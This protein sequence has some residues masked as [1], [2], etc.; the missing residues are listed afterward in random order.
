MQSK[1]FV[2]ARLSFFDVEFNNCLKDLCGG[3]LVDLISTLWLQLER[4][5]VHLLY[6]VTMKIGAIVVSPVVDAIKKS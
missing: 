4:V 1:S 6:L 5:R 2:L 3:S